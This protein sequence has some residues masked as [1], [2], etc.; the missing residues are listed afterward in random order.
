M[1]SIKDSLLKM[2][3]INN[4]LCIEQASRKP[5]TEIISNYIGRVLS[6][7]E[8]NTKLAK[9]YKFVK[10]TNVEENH[11]GFEFK[12][13]LN[14]DTNAFYP[15]NTRRGGGIYFTNLNNL[16]KWLKYSDMEMFYV[17]AVYIPDDA[18]VYIDDTGN[19]KTNKL[20]L[21]ERIKISDSGVWSD[22]NFCID[23]INQSFN[24]FK[25]IKNQTNDICEKAI[26]TGNVFALKYIKLQTN[27]LCFLAIKH[28]PFALQFV[29]NQTD[30]MCMEAIKQNDFVLEENEKLRRVLVLKYVENQ[31]DKI[32]MEAIKQHPFALQ[33]VKNQTYEICV[34]A[35]KRNAFALQFVKNQTHNL[36]MMAVKQVGYA[37][38]Y[39][40]NQTHKV[41]VEAIK[42]NPDAFRLIRDSQLQFM[43]QRDA[44][45]KNELCV[46]L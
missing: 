27:E 45:T 26:K 13:G 19:F 29:K 5:P 24:A 42:Q 16:A 34:E 11:N 9:V 28:N 43:V 25:F 38:K 44:K 8:F 39:V 12:N 33:Y 7:T 35:I 36:C 31:T 40:K 20:K 17:R 41:C 3:N 37:L 22:D 23:A 1:F 15:S 14:I 30:E 2:Q 6:G 32:C 4:G 18:M 46:I 10:L 21:S